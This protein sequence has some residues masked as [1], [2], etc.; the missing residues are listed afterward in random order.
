MHSDDIM[1]HCASTTAATLIR[2][3]GLMEFNWQEF[4]WKLQAATSNLYNLYTL[5]VFTIVEGSCNPLLLLTSA[6]AV[7]FYLLLL[8][9]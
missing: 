6:F 3:H 8:L 5:L 7:A 1:K 2:F 9:S 4:Q